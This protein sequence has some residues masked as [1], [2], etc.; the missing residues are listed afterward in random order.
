MLLQKVYTFEFL[1]T[2]SHYGVEHFHSKDSPP[3]ITTA[4]FI[5]PVAKLLVQLS[6]FVTFLEVQSNSGM[7][8]F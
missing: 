5:A 6:T 4:V 7:F 8:G 1:I 3:E 2:L